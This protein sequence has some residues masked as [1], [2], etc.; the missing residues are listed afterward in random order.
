MENRQALL[1]GERTV[2]YLYCNTEITKDSVNFY[3]SKK[4]FCIFY[5]TALTQ[6][7]LVMALRLT[8]FLIVS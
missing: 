1:L 8:T 4:I 3:W 2:L 5:L 7:L 6:I